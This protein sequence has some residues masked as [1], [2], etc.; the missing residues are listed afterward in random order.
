M[1]KYRNLSGDSNICCYEIGP[2]YIVVEFKDD[3]MYVYTY[4]SAEVSCRKNENFSS[5][6]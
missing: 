6:R 3:S 2:D 5:T 1:N 4:K